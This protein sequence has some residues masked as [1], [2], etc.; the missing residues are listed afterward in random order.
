MPPDSR[1]A[2]AS[3]AREERSACMKTA[4]AA[5]LVSHH[6]LADTRKENAMATS[7]VNDSISAMNK[8]AADN[9]RVMAT[10][11]QTSTAISNA[12][13]TTHTITA[14]NS[15]ATDAAKNASN[16]MRHAAKAS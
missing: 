11:T 1:A 15:A 10:S 9:A 5:E 7:S 3:A 14:A 12:A 13:T 16:D 8:A 2:P 4:G 6:R